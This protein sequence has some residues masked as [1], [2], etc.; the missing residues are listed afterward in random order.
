MVESAALLIDEVLPHVPMHQWVLSVP[1]GL[2]IL[3]ARNSAA[4]SEALRQLY[5]VINA[6]LIHKAGPS[7]ATRNVAR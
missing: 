7:N 1:F 5:R 2:R 4:L 6:F 3:F